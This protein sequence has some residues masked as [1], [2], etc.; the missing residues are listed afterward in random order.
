MGAVRCNA[1]MP[2]S[3]RA[4]DTRH[5][6]LDALR[7]G[8]AVAAVA[9]LCAAPAAQA[10]IFSA[11]DENGTAVLSNHASMPDAQVLV[12]AP[13]AAPVADP[14][15]VVTDTLPAPLPAAVPAA[16]PLAGIIRDAARRHA[17]PEAVLSAMVAVESGFDRRAVS[18]KGAKGLMQLMPATARR[19]GVKDVF[20]PDQNV[21]AGAA[22]LRVLMN[23][24]ADELPLALAAYNAGEGAVLR[25]GRRVP[26]YPE[27]QN[28]VRK[29]LR[30]AALWTDPNET[31]RR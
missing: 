14:L 19:F 25:A 22:Y 21:L 1:A 10:Q 17:L 28:Y 16:Q 11:I 6:A 24:F 13:V 15:S 31:V 18:P 7:R 12:E 5:P 4:A 8:A 9:I 3:C 26:A 2:F 23:L 27:T 29:V 20:A 30:Q